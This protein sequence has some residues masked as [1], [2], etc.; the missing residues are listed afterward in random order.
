MPQLDIDPRLKDSPLYSP[1]L[2]PVPASGR[3]WTRWSL[4][5]LWVGMAVC[6]PTY[7]L[8]VEMIASGMRWWEALLIITLANIIITIPMV[9]NGHG[10]VKYGVPFPVIGRAAFGIHGIH[11]PAILRALVACGW[12]G[13]QTWVGGLAIYAMWNALT[14]TTPTGELD[15]GQFISFGIFWLINVFFVWKGTES[16]KMLENL[17]A[18]ILII[19]GILLIVWGGYKAG[20]F[21]IVLDQSAQL[22]KPSGEYQLVDGKME[23]AIRPL[24]DKTG[25]PKAN[26]Y[27]LDFPMIGDGKGSSDW[28]PL[29]ATFPKMEV[30]PENADVKGVFEGDSHVMLQ[31]RNAQYSSKQLVV[32]AKAPEATL[33]STIWRY[34]VWLTVMVGFWATMSISISDITRYAKTQ[35]DQLAGQFIGLPGTMVLFSFVGIFVTCAAIINFD[36]ILAG[37]D[38]PWNPV[39]LLAR[40]NDPV[41]V[42]V[43]QLFMLIATLTTNIAANVIA[44]A[45]AFSNLLPKYL[46]FQKG[47]ILAC[48]IGII[49]CP[50]WLM[51]S[52]M[53]IL[54]FVSGWL[55]PVLGVL[56]AD[57]FIVRKKELSLSGLFDVAGPYRYKSGF[58]VTAFVALAL[59][60][61]VA[62]VGNF[63]PQLDFLYKLSWFTGFGTSLVVYAV[64]MRKS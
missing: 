30:L 49:L 41:V 38:A 13:I 21:G 55:G 15:A 17:S 34:L 36:D 7:M 10:G 62:M 43:A 4:A 5:A 58:N 57:Y 64:A 56:I 37:E 23:I 54:L 48:I 51:N 12:F 16:I 61:A 53:P 59:G 27:K 29:G 35:G 40:F 50:W 33:A 42:I 60:I 25:Q 11:F 44:P 24:H 39:A 2:A 3:T 52:I 26:E 22:E 45:N 63:F 8:A 19:L 47:G 6:I 32:K 9:L 20:G 28:K 18:P 1:D 31:F 46:D 14:G